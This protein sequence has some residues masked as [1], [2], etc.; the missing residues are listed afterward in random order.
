M[1]QCPTRTSRGVK[2]METMSTLEQLLYTT[3]RI[4]AKTEENGEKIGTS[5]IFNYNVKDKNYMFLVTNKHVVSDTI[6]GS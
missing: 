6:T 1:K 3:V 5:F 4:K 2:N